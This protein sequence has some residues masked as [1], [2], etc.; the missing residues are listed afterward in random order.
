MPSWASDLHQTYITSKVSP[1][2]VSTG[3]ASI[4]LQHC[5]QCIFNLKCRHLVFLRRQ[6]S[7]SSAIKEHRGL[8][9]T[10]FALSKISPSSVSRKQRPKFYSYKYANVDIIPYSVVKV[11]AFS[12]HFY[13][14]TYIN[15][16]TAH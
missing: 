11:H 8:L 7:V 12:F 2:G 14:L 5:R 15:Y 1:S 4:C 3:S 10:I 9:S 6:I 16:W 13:P